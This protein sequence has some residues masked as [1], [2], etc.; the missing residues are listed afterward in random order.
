MR[1]EGIENNHELQQVLWACY[2]YWQNEALPPPERTICYSW[3][4]RLHEE[5]FGTRFH[6][7][8]L[9]R[10]AEL[11]FLKQDDASRSGHRRYYR[12]M[13]PHGVEDLLRKW[14]RD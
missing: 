5:R 9:R 14:N 3:V 11:G 8:S 2:R 1:T 13:D 12:I 6:Q 4:L 7:S 10:L